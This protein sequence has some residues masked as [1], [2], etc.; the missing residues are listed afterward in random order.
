VVEGGMCVQHIKAVC[1]GHIQINVNGKLKYAKLG[2]MT[3]QTSTG[4]TFQG[5]GLKHQTTMEFEIQKQ[6]GI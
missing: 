6:N 4:N 3:E 1:S 2:K 5:G